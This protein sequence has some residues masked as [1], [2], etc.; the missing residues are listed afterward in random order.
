MCSGQPFLVIE[1]MKHAALDEVLQDSSIDLTWARR[2]GFAADASFGM[3]YLHSRD[4]PRIHRDLKVCRAG[5]RCF[6]RFPV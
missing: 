2:L 1:Y 5:G 6:L 3:A 4:P